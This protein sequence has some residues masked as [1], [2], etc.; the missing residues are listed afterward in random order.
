MLSVNSHILF[1][2]HFEFFQNCFK[3]LQSRANNQILYILNII[4]NYSITYNVH[5]MK[6]SISRLCIS[7]H[8]K[9]STK[10]IMNIFLY[11]KLYDRLMMILLQLTVLLW[12]MW[13]IIVNHDRVESMHKSEAFNTIDSH[14]VLSCL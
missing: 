5:C 3:Y 7:Y 4:G 1:T 11:I 8:S 6:I 13:F 12:L 2:F 9:K 14:T 10:G